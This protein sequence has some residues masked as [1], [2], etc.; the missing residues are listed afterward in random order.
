MASGK[1]LRIDVWRLLIVFF[2]KSSGALIAPDCQLDVRDLTSLL[3][4]RED[5]RLTCAGRQNEDLA[6]RTD[7][8]AGHRGIATTISVASRGRSTIIER[9]TPIVNRR[10]NNAC[11]AL[12]MPAC[13]ARTGCDEAAKEG[14]GAGKDQPGYSPRKPLVYERRSRLRLSWMVLRTST[15]TRLRRDTEAHDSQSGITG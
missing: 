7:H 14:A 11:C 2:R 13:S 15:H 12:S 4:K 8:R 5:R 10:A 6:R 3:I 1:D 9:P